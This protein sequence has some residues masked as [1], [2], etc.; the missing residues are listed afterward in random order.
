MKFKAMVD[1][2]IIRNYILLEMVKWL[3]LPYRQKEDLY[4]LVMISGDLIIYKNG[5]ICFETGLVEL[6]LKGQYIV[7][8]FNV[9]LLRKDKAVLGMPFL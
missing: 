6:E 8:L 9:L 5:M 7:M 4:S 1:N 3:K 2:E